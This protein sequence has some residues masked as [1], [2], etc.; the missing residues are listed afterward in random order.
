[1]ISKDSVTLKHDDHGSRVAVT[2]DE[3][4]CLLI[5]ILS[6]AV[7]SDDAPE[8]TDVSFVADYGKDRGERIVYLEMTDPSGLTEGFT[9]T[10]RRND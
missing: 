10:L 4:R 2:L 7:K 3:A 5:G 9:L 8:H 6:G 1:M